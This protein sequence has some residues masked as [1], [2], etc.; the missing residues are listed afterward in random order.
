MYVSI[1]TLRFWRHI[2]DY[3]L[4][5]LFRVNQVALELFYFHCIHDCIEH[6]FCENK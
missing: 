5:F 4:N 6:L 1:Q 2:L 3:N